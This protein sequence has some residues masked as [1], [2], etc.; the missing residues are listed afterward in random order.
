MNPAW[1]RTAWLTAFAT[2]MGILEAAV[3]VYLRELYYPGGFR[4]P[5]VPM[6]ARVALVEIVREACTI[7]MLLAPA[8][9]V[10]RHRTDGFFV[11]GF[12]FGVWDLVYY[13]ALLGFLGWPES[14][15]TWDLLFLIP[16][17][18]LS[19]VLY[20]VV[21]SL[22]LVTGFV[23]HEAAEATGRSIAPSRLGWAVAALGAFGVVLSLCWRFRD[24]LAARVPDRFPAGLFWIALAVAVAPFLRSA[25]SAF[26]GRRDPGA[27]AR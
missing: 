8:A 25:R 21:V 7:V 14:L 18:W 19:P 22:L 1:R 27:P 9:L 5:I 10:R 12:L 26:A 17:P 3:V 16:V 2:A 15:L 11:F 24:V 20:P 6:P 23:V 13:G 4:F